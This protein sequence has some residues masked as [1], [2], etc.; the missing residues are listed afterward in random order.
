MALVQVTRGAAVVLG[1]SLV[2]AA[3]CGGHDSNGG[4]HPAVGGQAEGGTATAQAGEG[5]GPNAGSATHP[6]G[7]SPVDTAGASAVGGTGEGGEPMQT[8]QAGQPPLQPGSGTIGSRCQATL[9]CKV[10]L[11]CITESMT[12][13]DGGAPP[14][15]LCTVACTQNT[16]CEKFSAGSLCYPFDVESPEGYCVEGCS[17]GQQGAFRKCHARPDFSCAPALLQDTGYDCASGCLAGE[18]CIAATNTCQLAIPACLPSCRGDLDCAAGLYCDQ[19][20]LGGKCVPTKP[21][22]KPLGEPCTVP[23]PLEPLEPDECLGYCQAD[24][25]GSSAGHCLSTCGLG[26]GCAWNPKTRLFDGACY[27]TSTLSQGNAAYGDLGFCAPA[28]NCAAECGDASLACLVGQGIDP[29]DTK[30]YA[31]VGLCFTPNPELNDIVVE[32]CQ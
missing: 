30:A 6:G 22:G 21:A 1:L 4:G 15:G 23:G 29:L 10:G 16:E 20:F 9:D 2:L 26:S 7:A 18:I 3:A 5:V 27:I 28:C 11:E 12:A 25:D 8:G 13:L 24:A 31:G 19:Q 14:H 17:F 32:Q